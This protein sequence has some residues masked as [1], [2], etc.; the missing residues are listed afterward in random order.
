MKLKTWIINLPN[1]P[2]LLMAKYLK[3]R[4]WVAFYLE[5]QCR[6]CNDGTC[7]LRLYED[8]EGRRTRSAQHRNGADSTVDDSSPI[9][10]QITD[11]SGG[12]TFQMICTCPSCKASGLLELFDPRPEPTTKQAES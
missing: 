9:N 11:E 4:G 10:K 3:K 6:T 2:N 8:S 1:L 5:E 7:W 12:V